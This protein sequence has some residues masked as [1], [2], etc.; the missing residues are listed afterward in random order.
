MSQWKDG[1]SY[2]SR[3]YNGP[4]NWTNNQN[5]QYQN[6]S[7]TYYNQ[8]YDPNSQ[9]VSFNQFLNQ[10]Q[11]GSSSS[12]YNNMQYQNYLVNQYDYT[13]QPPQSSSN[14]YYSQ[15]PSQSNEETMNSYNASSSSGAPQSYNSDTVLKSKLTPTAVEFVPKS[16]QQLSPNPG[17][18]SDTKVIEPVDTE[19]TYSSSSNEANSL[20]RNEYSRN[21]NA[22]HSNHS[23]NHGN[24]NQ[25][26]N[27]HKGNNKDSE[28]TR[29]FYNSRTSQDV[30]NGGRYSE[31]SMG[32]GKNW[33]GSQRLRTMD[34]NSVDDE[35]FANNYL[36]YNKQD[37]G[38][39][40]MNSPIK[41]K[42]PVRKVPTDQGN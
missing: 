22:E 12:N 11:N 13:N 31:N 37:N 6:Q 5:S 4:N 42:T 36:Q 32:R 18:P 27:N 16:S 3:Q 30:R 23:S 39:N 17:T 19:L 26:K 34:R 29:T 25:R 38:K 7:T 33:A 20:P 41:N 40:K 24:R 2:N 15:Q 8:Q 9:Y 21:S 1:Y 28:G 10:M 14:Q 35:Q